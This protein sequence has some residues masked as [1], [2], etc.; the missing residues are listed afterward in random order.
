MRQEERR[1]RTFAALVRAATRAFATLG[2]EGGSLDAIAASVGL[3]KGAVYTHFQTKLELFL[4][5]V[6]AT[7]ADALDRTGRAAESLRETDD[8]FVAAGGYLGDAPSETEHMALM[9]EI[10]RAAATSSEVRARL[11]AF[12]EE[13]LAVLG[14]AAIGAG[15]PPAKATQ[16]AWMV[17][18]LID[19]DT[20]E[21]RLDH[22]AGS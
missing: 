2:Y 20:L 1:A 18:R 15:H 3:S 22:V 9:A 13:R 6:D 21:R 11:E 14:A 12:R 8:P 17:A 16:R 4:V 19:G 10:W 5:V 7:L